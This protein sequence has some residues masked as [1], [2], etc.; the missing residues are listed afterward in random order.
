MVHVVDDDEAVRDSIVERVSSV[1]LASATYRRR[2]GSSRGTM[3]RSRVASCSTCAWRISAAPAL[4]AELIAMGTR[5]P[6]VFISGHGTI[7]VAIGTIKAGAVDFVRAGAS[8]FVEHPMR[9]SRLVS[10]SRRATAAARVAYA[11]CR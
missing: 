9:A 8:E 10:S 6:I 5:I 2:T 7:P 4:Q 11:H 3:P 1:G